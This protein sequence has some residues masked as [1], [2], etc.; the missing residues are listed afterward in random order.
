VCLCLIPHISSDSVYIFQYQVRKLL[1]NG[2]TEY[3]AKE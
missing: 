3:F 1:E 2:E